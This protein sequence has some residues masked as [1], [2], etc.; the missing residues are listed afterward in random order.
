GNNSLAQ[1]Q[2]TE[3]LD[4]F[5]THETNRSP[6][7]TNAYGEALGNM[8]EVSYAKGDFV[9]AA[10]QLESALKVLQNDRRGQAKIHLFLGYING[11]TGNPERAAA[12]IS[13]ASELYN[14][15][16]DKTGQGLALTALGL[17][18]N[19]NKQHIP[20]IESHRKAIDIFRSIGDRHS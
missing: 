8:A 17:S 9:K 19:L 7:A 5:N 6:V 12:E 3:S 11:G 18:L 20:A 15:T 10:S 13:R 4:L 14:E 1:K 2:L 16:N